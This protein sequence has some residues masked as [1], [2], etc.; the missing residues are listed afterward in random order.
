MKLYSYIDLLQIVT[1]AIKDKF[2]LQKKIDYTHF[3]TWNRIFLPESNKPFP[4]SNKHTH[5]IW[6]LFM[7]W[8]RQTNKIYIFT[9]AMEAH[10]SSVWSNVWEGLNWETLTGWTIISENCCICR[11]WHFDGTSLLA[12][13]IK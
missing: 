7:K 2:I 13:V 12:I 4:G 9:H 8:C 3:P 6:R 11:T 5:H 1:I 10:M